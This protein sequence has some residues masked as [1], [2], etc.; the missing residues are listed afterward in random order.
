MRALGKFKHLPH[1]RYRYEAQL[2]ADMQQWMDYYFNKCKIKIFE[3]SFLKVM[4]IC[5]CIIGWLSLNF[6]ECICPE[7]RTL[8]KKKAVQKHKGGKISKIADLLS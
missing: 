3:D 6:Q 7:R 5:Y 1:Y 8:P 4:T 2:E